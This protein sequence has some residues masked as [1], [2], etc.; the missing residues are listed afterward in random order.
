MFVFGFEVGLEEP[1]AFERGTVDGAGGCCCDA[2]AVF[3]VFQK[4]NAQKTSITTYMTH[5]NKPNTFI[6][7][8]NNR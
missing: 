5:A 4:C 6:Y 3:R 7:V 2:L 8:N 1:G